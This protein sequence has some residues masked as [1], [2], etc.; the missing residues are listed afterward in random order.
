MSHGRGTRVLKAISSPL[1][2][3]VLNLLYDRGPL[4]YTKIMSVLRLS[5]TSDA[6]KFAYHLKF[7]LNTDLIEPDVETRK[8]RLTELGQ[9]L[10]G[11][12]E[13]IDERVSKRRK[14]FVRTS[15]L[16]IEEFD[17]N[18]I[19]LSL[20]KEAGVPLDLAQKIS[21]E[22]EERLSEFKTKYL[23]APLIREFVNAIL[24]EKGLEEYRHKLT[25]LGIPVY[26]V[27]ELIK[28]TGALSLGVETIH[29]AAGDRVIEEYTLLNVLPRDIADAHLSGY[30]HINN[31][32]CW[33]LK[34]NEFLHDL[35]LFLQRGLNIER[36][37]FIG[38]SY[39]SPK[40]FE[41]AL[42]ITSNVLKAAATDISGEQTIDF[43]NIFL[44]PFVRGLPPER[45]KEGL[46][47][48]ISD[49]NH[50][51]S[52]EG[53]PIM[54]SVGLEF[55]VPNFL[56]E[57]EA[58]GL[59]GKRIGCY[60]DYVEE[61][62]LIASLLLDMMFEDERHKPVFNPSLIIKIR[63]DVLENR[64][65][66][67]LLLQSHKLAAERGLPYFANLCPKVQKHASYSATGCRFSD[68]WRGDWELDTLRTG[69]I[70]SV[71]INL[72]RAAYEA[73]RNKARFIK[74][75]DEQLELSIRALE[76][77]YLTI[78]QRER[79]GLLPFLMRKVDGDQYFRIENGTRLIGFVGLNEAIESLSGKGIWED[80]GLDLA[81]ET[82]RYLSESVEKRAKKPETRGSL[83]MMSNP[84]AARR[85]AELDVQKYGWSTVRIQ[86]TK[87]QPFYTNTVAA[88]LS[89][90]ISLDKRLKIEEKFHRLCPGS[91]LAILQ[92]E[93]SNLD[94][95]E[96]LSTTK[97][98]VK[99]FD[100][101]LYTYNR[102]I[103]YCTNCEKIFNG[104]L[105]KCPTC[106]SV[107]KLVRFGHVPS[108]YLPSSY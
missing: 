108:K 99:T 2:L 48:F 88:P 21:R 22:T 74:L 97:R 77:K 29:K 38:P 10:I 56:R 72:P 42:L 96:L 75:L 70:D 5:P 31:L 76:I 1:R 33:V 105:P 9:M 93:N 104:T 80:E 85:L 35:R 47:F 95:K 46:N 34:P 30:L 63:P 100:V 73:G 16:A 78:R 87:E 28:S 20:V 83:S 26:D 27:T 53:R 98:L 68:D 89:S 24:I 18:K 57:K 91:H 55:V 6:G 51:S 84:N 54:A 52:G 62:R 94:T 58:I 19:A 14:M 7:L 25:R 50:S 3:Q 39:I 64:G 86:G 11:V 65:C 79:E 44:A 67:T 81:E 71:I 102:N 59:G 17:R 101:G 60:A 45:I 40:N 106:G 15:R 12:A 82:V 103:A 36:T 23:T 41:S 37:G 69:S 43:F 92:L 61:S 66:E 90:D 107:N 8:Y 32:G 49:L 13:N 4:P